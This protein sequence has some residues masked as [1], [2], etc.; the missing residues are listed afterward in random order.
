MIA[1]TS[2][3]AERSFAPKVARPGVPTGTSGGGRQTTSFAW[4]AAVSGAAVGTT[5]SGTSSVWP[6]ALRWRSQVCVAVDA[7]H[8]AAAAAFGAIASTSPVRGRIA[9]PRSA[10]AAVAVTLPS[11]VPGDA[12]VIW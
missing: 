2:N 3:V 10:A 8:C 11:F 9:P 5:Y 4:P 1:E 6:A 7:P 12:V